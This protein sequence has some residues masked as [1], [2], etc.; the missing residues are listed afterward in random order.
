MRAL[1]GGGEGGCGI[2]KIGGPSLKHRENPMNF[3][4]G[5][6]ICRA[7]S[8]SCETNSVPKSHHGVKSFKILSQELPRRRGTNCSDQDRLKKWRRQV[9]EGLPM[10]L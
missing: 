3:Q 6:V 1:L 9:P 7:L 4:N 2:Q 5:D 10:T 8:I